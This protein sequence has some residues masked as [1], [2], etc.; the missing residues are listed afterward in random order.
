MTICPWCERAFEPRSGQGGKP[1][2]YCGGAC[3]HDLRDTAVRYVLAEVAAGQL[4]LDRVGER[5]RSKVRV[6]PRGLGASPAIPEPPEPAS[7]PEPP[8]GR[9]PPPNPAAS[10]P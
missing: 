3:R 2:V 9:D 8:A 4:D 1:Q 10:P 5:G 7:P 6:A